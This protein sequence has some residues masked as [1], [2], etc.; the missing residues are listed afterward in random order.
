MARQETD[1]RHAGGRNESAGHG[2]LQGVRT[3]RTDHFA[4]IEGAKQ[5]GGVDDRSPPCHLVVRHIP[6]EGQLT[7]A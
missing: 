1:H 7:R 4:S 5:A 6:T 3:G 2:D